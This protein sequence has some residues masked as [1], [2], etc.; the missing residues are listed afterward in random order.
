MANLFALIH[1]VRQLD[2]PGD[3]IRGERVLREKGCAECHSIDTSEGGVG[4]DLAKWGSYANPVIWAQMMWQHAPVMEKAMRQAGMN[5]PKLE[6][7]DLVHIVA[8]VRSA[9]ISGEKTYLRPGSVDTGRRL[10]S[11]KG[12]S[13]C[14]PGQGPDLAQMELP[15]SVG[16]LAA[17]MWNHSPEMTRLMR[18]RDVPR[19]EIDPQELADILTYL[20]TLQDPRRTGDPA[21][22][23][24]VFIE[25][26]CAQCHESETVTEDDAPSLPQISQSASPV[27]MAAAMWNHGETM[28]ERMTEAGMAWP[29]FADDEMADLLAYLE[30]SQPTKGE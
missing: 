29:V 6:G 27:T 5:W 4:P 12:C 11:E 15:G 8:Y 1:F 3:P 14:H 21:R 16:S 24:H 19:L 13:S 22:G 28:L 17:R 7:A 9:G 10:F 26:D 18:E 30:N 23:E 2:E 20:L 25:K